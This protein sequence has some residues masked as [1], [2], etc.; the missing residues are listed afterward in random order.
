[1]WVAEWSSDKLGELWRRDAR[2]YYEL[3]ESK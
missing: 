2:D 3:A 1:M